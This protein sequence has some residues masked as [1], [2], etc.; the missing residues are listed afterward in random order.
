M[1]PHT[2][3]ISRLIRGQRSAERATKGGPFLF[4]SCSEQLEA[5]NIPACASRKASR[6][7]PV[8]WR[9]TPYLLGDAQL[10]NELLAALFSFEHDVLN[11]PSA[12]EPLQQQ[13]RQVFVFVLRRVRHP[14]QIG[15]KRLLQEISPST[16]GI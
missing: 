16:R 3:V 1:V 13:H 6:A 11:R 2:S 7:N 14:A 9:Q 5:D 15:S 12:D 4:L 10:S 8:E